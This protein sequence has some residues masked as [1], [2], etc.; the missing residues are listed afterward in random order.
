MFIWATMN[1]ADQGVFPM[2]T[3]F[4][5]RWSFEYLGINENEEGVVGTVDIAGETIDWNKLRRAI[6]DKLA[7][8]Y[9]VNEDKLMGPYFLAKKLLVTDDAGKIVDQDRF[10]KAF[11]S[12]V[13]M[14]LYEDAAKQHKHKLFEGCDSSKYSSVCDDF[15]RIGIRIFGD[16]FKAEFYEQQEG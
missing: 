1:S 13:I 2:D 15:D 6:N 10:I 16:N 3:A 9:K 12:K 8:D 5:R 7:K 11:K 4:K 14:Y